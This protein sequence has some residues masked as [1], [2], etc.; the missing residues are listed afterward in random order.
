MPGPGPGGPRAGRGAPAGSSRDPEA[1]DTL[2]LDELVIALVPEL[3]AREDE[4]SAYGHGFPEE[5]RERETDL[6]R[7]RAHV[8]AADE[9]ARRFDDWLDKHPLAV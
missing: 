3:A 6:Q 8:H 4:L 5:M 1:Y 9:L 2:V 7:A